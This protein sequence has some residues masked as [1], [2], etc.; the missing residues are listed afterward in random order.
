MQVRQL[1]KGDFFLAL[2]NHTGACGVVLDPEAAL[3]WVCDLCQ[4][5]K[6]PE[7]SLVCALISLCQVHTETT[8]KQNYACLL[9][10]RPKKDAKKTAFYPPSDTYLRACKP[11]EG[12]GW[13]HVLCSVFMPEIQFADVSRLRLV[14]GVSTVPKERWMTVS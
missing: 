6:E 4:N 13:V 5:E 10:P 12:Q 11:T 9:C 3:Q 8:M 2:S 1:D 14:E 7:A